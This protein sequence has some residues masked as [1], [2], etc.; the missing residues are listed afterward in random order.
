MRNTTNPARPNTAA[1]R[2][3]AA[4]VARIDQYLPS[5]VSICLASYADIVEAA[6]GTKFGRMAA[7]QA[8]TLLK[9]NG[10][11]PG[12]ELRNAFF[13][14]TETYGV[15]ACDLVGGHLAFYGNDICVVERWTGGVKLNATCA[16]RSVYGFTL[17][18]QIKVLVVG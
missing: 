11:D 7:V 12:S 1:R 5:G 14:F 3:A 18:S 9:D 2:L 6:S 13:D 16:L 4:L 15:P 8:W 10:I 17:D